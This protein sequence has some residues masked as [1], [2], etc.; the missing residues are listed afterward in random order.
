MS[1]FTPAVIGLNFSGPSQ[2][3]TSSTSLHNTRAQRAT[4]TERMCSL[5]IKHGGIVGLA[6]SKFSVARAKEQRP[7][8]LGCWGVGGLLQKASD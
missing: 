3:G 5:A 6:V 4:D 2:E 1:L 8:L 7:S